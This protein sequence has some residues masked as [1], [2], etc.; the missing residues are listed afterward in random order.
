MDADVKGNLLIG[1]VFVLILAGIGIL[2]VYRAGRPGRLTRASLASFIG[3][4]LAGLSVLLT[5]P[6][7]G[8]PICATGLFV[9]GEIAAVSSGFALYA[10]RRMRHGERLRIVVCASIACLA[11]LFVLGRIFSEPFAILANRVMIGDF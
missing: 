4:A 11:L 1:Q 9:E 3:F 7:T 8:T 5:G 2:L 6:D 10:V